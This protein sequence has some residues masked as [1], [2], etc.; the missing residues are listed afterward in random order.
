MKWKES[1]NQDFLNVSTSC[2]FF[3]FWAPPHLIFPN[4]YSKYF[5]FELSYPRVF[6]KT[7]KWKIPHEAVTE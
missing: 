3:F 5:A 4:K 1:V 2:F 6:V 7:V